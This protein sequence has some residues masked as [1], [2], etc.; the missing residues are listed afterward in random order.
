MRR[1]THFKNMYKICYLITQYIKFGT[2]LLAKLILKIILIVLI[3]GFTVLL[4]FVHSTYHYWALRTIGSC[5]SC[6]ATRYPVEQTQPPPGVKL[7]IQ[8]VS[9]VQNPSSHSYKEINNVMYR[10]F[11]Q[12]TSTGRYSQGLEEDC[13]T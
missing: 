11:N 13:N 5:Y 7:N 3:R 1:S 10:H 4:L 12:V 9:A 2:E 8:Y 6:D